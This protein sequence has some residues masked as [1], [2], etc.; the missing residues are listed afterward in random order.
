[1]D[2]GYE[3][4]FVLKVVIICNKN[5]YFGIGLI[6]VKIDLSDGNN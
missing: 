5:Y 2:F 3:T 6:P 1:M 4:L